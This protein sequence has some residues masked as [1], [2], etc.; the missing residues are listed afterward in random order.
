MSNDRSLSRRS[1]LKKSLTITGGLMASG[2]LDPLAWARLVEISEQR[3][4]ALKKMGFKGTVVKRGDKTFDSYVYGELWNKLHPE[5]SPDI[6]CVVESDDDVITCIKFASANKIKVAVRGGGHNWCQPSVRQGGML[7]DLSR[8]TRVVSIDKDN[9]KAIVEPIVSNREMQ[10][11]LNALGLSYPTGHC[12]QVKMSGYLLSGGMAWNHGVWGPGV[13]SIEAIDLVTAEGKLIK[14]SA[15]ENQDFFWACRGAGPATFCVVL[16]YHLKLY[17]LP[18]YIG[19]SAYYFPYSQLLALSDWVSQT[20]PKLPANVEFSIFAITAP[21]KYKEQCAADGSKDKIVLV[22]AVSFTDTREQALKDLDLVDK[23]PLMDH[24][25]ERNFCAETNFEKLFDASGALWPENLR[26]KVDAIFSE[27]NLQKLY[28][29]VKD[30]FRDFESPQTVLMFAAF[31][32]PDLPLKTPA[33]AAFSMTG[34]FYGGP[35]TMWQEAKDD[36]RSIA[37]HE[38]CIQLMSPEICGHYVSETDTID[39][40][41][42]NK[43]A[44]KGKNFERLAVLRKKHDPQGLFFDWHEGLS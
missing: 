12:P 24:A 41:D 43:K 21:D 9:K 33:D 38:K 18:K 29:P 36:S 28:G 40:A 8:L 5:R 19:S 1:L 14:A 27:S 16:R 35:W 17:D 42:Y 10:K 11:A 6:V 13:G 26:C 23:C 37:W 30:H 4:A 3:S 20:A 34:N 39:H 25:L 7:I 22:T 44:Y 2:L 15:T 32:G 31:T